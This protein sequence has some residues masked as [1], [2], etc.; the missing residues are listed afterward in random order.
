MMMICIIAKPNWRNKQNRSKS[1]DQNIKTRFGEREGE[2]DEIQF[3]QD[4][5]LLNELTAVDAQESF[6]IFIN[7]IPSGRR[8]QYLFMRQIEGV[9]RGVNHLFLRRRRILFR[10]TTKPKRSPPPKKKDLFKER[11][12]MAVIWNRKSYK[13]RGHKRRDLSR[14]KHKITKTKRRERSNS[15][16]SPPRRV[17]LL[18][19]SSY[20]YVSLGVGFAFFPRALLVGVRISPRRGSVFI[21]IRIF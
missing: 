15:P 20:E 10:T 7:A 11:N 9:E 2:R 14:N 8:I 3:Q 4:A 1:L 19:R 5:A 6:N 18:V 17:F 21:R 16:V 13:I 12:A